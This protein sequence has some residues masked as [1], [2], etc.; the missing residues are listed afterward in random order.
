MTKKIVDM[1]SAKQK[2]GNL[3]VGDIGEIEVLRRRV[4]ELESSQRLGLVWRDIPEAVETLL[5]DEVPVLIAE[6]GLDVAGKLPSEQSHILIEGDNLHALHVLQAT[7]RGAIDVIYIDPPYNTGNDFMYNDTLIDD[8]HPW[9]HSAW[10]SFMEKRLSLAR[11][12]LTEEGVIAISIG[13]DEYANLK[14]L[15][16]H[17]FGEANFLTMFVWEKTQHFGRQKVNYYSNA[18]FILCY[19]NQV[20][21]TATGEKKKREVMV[22]YIKS[23][24]E[25]APLYN[26]SNKLNTLVFPVKSVR[27]NIPDG[28]Y[29][30]S[31]DKKYEVLNSVKVRQGFNTTPLTLKFKS[32]WSQEFM[33]AEI[34]KGTTF[35]VKTESFAIRAV[36]H[37]GKT[38]RESPKQL[39]FTNRNNQHAAKNRFG[40]P[41]SNQESGTSELAEMIGPDSNFPYP[42]PSSLLEYL[43]SMYFSATHGYPQDFIVLDFFAGSGTTLQAVASLNSLD[44]GTRRCILVTNNESNICRDVTHKRV[45][46]AL[47]GKWKSGTRDPLPGSLSFYKTGFVKRSKSP[48]RMRTEIAKHTVDLIAI[49]EGAGKTVSRTGELSVLRGINKTVAVVAG[50]DP[51]HAKLCANAE[52][53]V[54]DGDRKVVYLF[55]WSNQGVEAEFA[56]LW[57]G[58]EVEPLPAEMLAALRRNAPQPQ[59]FNDGGKL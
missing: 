18:D 54:R 25:D 39:I 58:W 35:L 34:A 46:A 31:S 13:E 16:D 32:R 4:T 57:P 50:L 45:K 42:K 17:I 6:P 59:L 44:G 5:R 29:R 40:K 7:H 51:D 10:L 26:A 37:E 53:K 14:L 36:Y 33:N 1:Q 23:E 24:L 8:K 27:C 41:V 30:A 47:T 38:S 15:C 55:T 2:V 49:K 11:S 19:V 43:I 52:K 21:E 12:L 20:E 22:E 28:I 3:A 9:R 48:D 56:A